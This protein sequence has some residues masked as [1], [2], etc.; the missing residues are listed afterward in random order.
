MVLDQFSKKGPLLKDFFFGIKIVVIFGKER[1]VIQSSQASMY[2]S[3][4]RIRGL[5]GCELV[6]RCAMFSPEE[7]LEWSHGFAVHYHGIEAARGAPFLSYFKK[8]EGF[9]SPVNEGL[10]RGDEV[11]FFI[12]HLNVITRSLLS[13]AELACLGSESAS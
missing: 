3:T 6:L 8:G 1:V 10:A 11:V 12:G 4:K 9:S 7:H 13:A 2:S 5:L